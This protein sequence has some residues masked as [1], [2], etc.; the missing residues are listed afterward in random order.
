[1]TSQERRG[2]RV[3]AS[4]A[5]TN[6]IVMGPSIGTIGIFFTPLIK[7]FGWSRAEVSRLATAFLL[8]MGI[9]NPI[10]GWLLDRI[11][12]RL[13]MAIGVVAAGIGYI[14]ASRVHALSPL[15]ALFALIGVGVGAS[16]ILP[17]MIV[18]ANWMAKQRALAIGITIAG[19]GLGGCV[20]PPLVAHLILV[21]GWRTAMLCIAGPMFVLAV[22]VVLVAVQTRPASAEG[23]SVAEEAADLP[24]LELGP[25][26]RSWS[27]W[28]IALMQFSFTIAFTGGYFH[29]VPFLIGAGYSSANRGI[30]FWRPGC[31]FAGRLCSVGHPGRQV[32]RQDGA[33]NRLADTGI[34]HDHCARGR[35]PAVRVTA[36]R[37]VYRDLRTDDWLRYRARNRVVGG[38]LR[39]A[40]VRFTRR[41]C[42]IHRHRRF[43]CGSDCLRANL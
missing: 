25:A 30:Y 3:V 2:W 15:V 5:F 23:R 26:L 39:A 13:V 32:R 1:M 34:K 9:V 22:P 8:A 29:M 33:G 17:G 27:F 18:A 20:M 31:G 19:A 28:A 11:E 16:T 7:E 36:D 42:R 40:P 38:N 43:G 24:G 21:Y 37:I 35:Q 10:V 41:Y 4:L 14:L 6:L 12:A